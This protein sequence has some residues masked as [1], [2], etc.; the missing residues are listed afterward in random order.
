MEELHQKYGS[1]VK[2]QLVLIRGANHPIPEL[3]FLRDTQ[4]QPI[5]QQIESFR[6][7]YEV[8]GLSIPTAIDTEDAA[9]ETSLL[10]W[11][12]RISVLNCDG[13]IALDVVR[14]L[15]KLEAWLESY[16]ATKHAT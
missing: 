2:F 12:E 16:V 4:D 15:D 11:P 1:E 14:S 8:L 9:T 10:A 7:A 3:E 5:D 6:K 13:T